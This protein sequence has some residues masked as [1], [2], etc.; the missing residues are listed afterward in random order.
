MYF[1][2]E[3]RNIKMNTTQTAIAQAVKSALTI[4]DIKAS[5]AKHLTM[6]DCSEDY[7]YT[8]FAH[9]LDTDI[10]DCSSTL[11]DMGYFYIAGECENESGAIGWSIG[12]N[13]L[14]FSDEAIGS[15]GFSDEDVIDVIT[16]AVKIDFKIEFSN[17]EVEACINKRVFLFLKDV[18]DFNALVQDY[19]N[20]KEE[21]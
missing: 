5:A 21:N 18:L 4:D 6:K 1:L 3:R 12:K 15:T 16:R 9:K 19:L 8:I 13:D 17:E 2:T 11:L 20:S 7:D 10:S 14:I